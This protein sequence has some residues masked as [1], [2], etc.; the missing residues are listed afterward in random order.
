MATGGATHIHQVRIPPPRM[1]EAKETTHTLIHW[2]N[3]F[4]N[5]FRR[6]D[7]YQRFFEPGATWDPTDDNYGFKDETGDRKRSAAMLK[8][9]LLALLQVMAG[10]LPF[11]YVT[12]KILTTT[13]CMQDCYDIIHDLYEAEVNS[14]TFLDM[15]TMVKSTTETYRTFYERIVNHVRLHLAKPNQRFDGLSSGLHGDKLNIT[16]LNMCVIWWLAK[17]DANLVNLVKMEFAT[18]LRNGDQLC[19]L[20]PRICRSIDCLLQ[21]QEATVQLLQVADNPISQATTDGILVNKIRRNDNRFNKKKSCDM[22]HSG[23]IQH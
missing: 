10:H 8:S 5:Y 4:Y 9:D 3:A 16:M 1:L 15:A 13:T 18:Q 2:R 6:D 12:E 7:L 20:V 14:N 23:R 19:S 21:R 11:S 22:S 17:I